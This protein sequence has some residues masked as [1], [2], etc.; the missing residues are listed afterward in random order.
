MIKKMIIPK[1]DGNKPQIVKTN[2][3]VLEFEEY[4]D[5]IYKNLNLHILFS[6]AVLLKKD[7]IKERY[8]HM[9]YQS[10]TSYE[11]VVK[12][13]FKNGVCISSEDLSEE[14]AKDRK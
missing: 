5:L 8:V 11:K 3:L 10:P 1:I 9:G 13:E 7:F 6:G 4:R 12:L 2:G 14:M